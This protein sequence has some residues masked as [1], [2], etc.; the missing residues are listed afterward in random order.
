MLKVAV[1]GAT[2]RMGLELIKMIEDDSGRFSLSAKASRSLGGVENWNAD[3]VD[4]VVDFALPESFD[5]VFK[6]CADNGKPL[7]S[8]TTGFD[9][10]KYTSDKLGFPF[11]YSGNYSLGM[12]ALIQS[13]Q[14]FRKMDVNL[15]VWVEDIHHIH[16][17][18]APSGTAVKIENEIKRSLKPSGAK[19]DSVREGEV[20][21]IHKVHIESAN[22]HIV[23]KHE[24]LNRGVFAAGALNATEW[25]AGQKPGVYKFEDYLNF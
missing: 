1:S 5:A 14:N 2:G 25:L 8:G 12:A 3:E 4:V 17:L 15:N 16:K 18:D 20:F 10:N 13:I 23:L 22:E 9:L 6:W 11:M 21:G 19:I 24:A 7:V